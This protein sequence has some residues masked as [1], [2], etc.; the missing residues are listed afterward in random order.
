MSKATQHYAISGRLLALLVLCIVATTTVLHFVLS[1]NGLALPHPFRP[2][3]YLVLED[4]KVRRVQGLPNRT[5]SL[6]ACHTPGTPGVAPFWDYYRRSGYDLAMYS[7]KS[8]LHKRRRTGPHWCCVAAVRDEM[9]ARPGR[10]VLYVDIDTKLRPD[11]WCALPDAAPIMMNS[12]FRGEPEVT[13]DFTM[14]GTGVQS[15]A[16]VVA[17]GARGL[18]ALRRWERA[19]YRGAFWDQGALHLQEKGVCGVPG[20]IACTSNPEQNYCHCCTVPGRDKQTCIE[21]LF[22]GTMPG[23]PI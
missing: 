19:H 6:V 20:W 17:A 23:C 5:C 10:R 7:A 22:N 9:R 12:L 16:F 14:Y 8:V 2:D 11:E 15:N 4:V 21:G 1:D 13:A 3:D 18:R